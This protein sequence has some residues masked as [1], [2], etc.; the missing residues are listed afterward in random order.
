MS[1]DRAADIRSL[2]AGMGYAD[3]VADPAPP[4]GRNLIWTGYSTSAGGAPRRLFAKR[5]TGAVA[6]TAERFSRALHFAEFAGFG[7]NS[8]AA[9]TPA[10]VASEEGARLLIYDYRSGPSA[11]ELPVDDELCRECGQL[12]ALLHS[13]DLTAGISAAPLARPALDEFRALP[14]RSYLGASGGELAMWRLLQQDTAL[15]SAIAALLALED[16]APR[17]P[18]HCDLRLDQFRR[19]EEGL[20]LTD[21]EE[22]RAADPARDVGSLA[23]DIV[24]QALCGALSGKAGAGDLGQRLDSAF[25][26]ARGHVSAMWESYLASVDVDPTGLAERAG[27]FAGWHLIDRTLALTQ[28]SGRLPA[29]GKVMLGVGQMLL[30]SGSEAGARVG[31]DR[32]A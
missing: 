16:D 22:F 10:L 27:R 20:Y 3:F 21:W 14:L 9:R 23:G 19:D 13:R 32:S 4:R 31:L 1:A 6:D 8:L 12:I 7:D 24:Y 29:K 11:F 25:G 17:V 18:A 30:L 15:I 5:L 26:R 2:L 28:I